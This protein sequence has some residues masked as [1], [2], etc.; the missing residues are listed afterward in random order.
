MES[1]DQMPEQTPPD[2]FRIEELQVFQSF[3]GQSLTDVNY[4]LWVN[5]VQ[6]GQALFR[7]LYALELLFE[8][9][10]TLLLSSGED[11]EMIRI[12]SPAE[13][14]KTAEALRTLHNALTI[15]RFHAGSLPLWL[16]VLNRPLDAIRLSKNE[17]GFYYNDALVLDFGEKRILIR[18]SDKD[19]LELGEM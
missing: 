14:V 2:C 8:G 17:E 4:F 9:D 6:E 19:G 1:Q 5:Q 13:L 10:E 12:S 18:L 3:E 7:F 15:Q 11:S 16:P